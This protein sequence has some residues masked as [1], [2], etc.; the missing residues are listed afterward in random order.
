MHDTAHDWLARTLTTLPPRRSVC[1]LGSRN[2]NGSARDL[3][4]GV[5]YVGVDL[6]P[7]EGVDVVANAATWGESGAYDTVLCCEVLEHTPDAARICQNAYRLLKPGGVF[8]MTAAGEGRE[9][10]SGFDGG[11]PDEDEYYENVT[12]KMLHDWLQHFVTVAVEV[13]TPGDIYALAFKG[14]LDACGTEAVPPLGTR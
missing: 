7:G 5:R 10:H 14:P 3:F 11:E 8:L 6:W 2:V 9:P 4:H 1:E 12:E 13:G